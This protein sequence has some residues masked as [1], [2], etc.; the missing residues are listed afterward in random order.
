MLA[1]YQDRCL[2]SPSIDD[3]SCSACRSAN[4]AFVGAKSGYQL[5][6]CLGCGT[7]TTSRAAGD[8]DRRDLFEH[9]YDRASFDIPAATAESLTRLASSFEPFRKTGRL[10]DVGY[11]EGG[12]LEAAERTGW[13]C[14]GTEL[15]LRA[16]EYGARRG[17]TV[18]R[19]GDLDDQFPEQ[20]FD[21]VTMIEFLEHV[22]EPMHF[23]QAALRWLRPGGVLY[24]TTPNAQSLNRR[25][26]GLGWSIFAPPDH[27]TIWTARGLRAALAASGFR[28]RR[29]RT[30]G[31]NPSE[32]IARFP[33]P[34]KTAVNP[35]NRQQAALDLN[36]AFSRSPVRRTAKRA[37][38]LLLSSVALGDG[39]KIWATPA[40]HAGPSAV[41]E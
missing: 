39:I 35:V 18:A 20:A 37:I 2:M 38:N 25:L 19:D 15:D 16:L 29:V 4:K 12:L 41:P 10:I 5:F 3:L 34:N 1:L 21:V 11:G 30:E 7:I 33:R 27:L 28:C 31:L 17:W 8:N 22:S 14:Y 24:L 40:T 36:R 23:L 26:L 9:Y 6:Q 13:D 32:I